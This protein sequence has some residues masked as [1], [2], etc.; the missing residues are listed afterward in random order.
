MTTGQSWRVLKY[1]YT[2]GGLR[3]RISALARR[4]TYLEV[5]FCLWRRLIGPLQL[6]IHLVQDRRTGEQKPHWDNKNKE[7][8]HLKLCIGSCVCLLF[9]LSQCDFC[10]PAWR[11]CTTWK[12]S[13]KG[14]IVSS[15][16][17][18]IFGN[19]KILGDDNPMPLYPQLG[20]SITFVHGNW[21]SHLKAI[22]PLRARVEGIFIWLSFL[23][24]KEDNNSI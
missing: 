6:A 15:N 19:W 2:G 9:V 7:N 13:R 4:R 17:K 1:W 12:A 18:K 3:T 20:R 22:F 5:W 24:Q 21:F 8:Y 16:S 23:L 10:S 14:S 11:F